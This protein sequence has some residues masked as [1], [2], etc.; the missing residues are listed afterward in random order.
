MGA[1]KL[2]QLEDNLKALNF[3]IPSELSDRLDAVSRPEA[4]FPYSFFSPEI[5]SMIH[6]GKPVG[7]KPPGYAPD[8][9]IQSAGAGV[10]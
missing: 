8:V 1:T 3:E 4:Q 6:G 9:L 2:S 10:S 7:L 5:Q